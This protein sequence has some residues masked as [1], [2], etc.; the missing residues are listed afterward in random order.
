[1]LL[2]SALF[3]FVTACSSDSDNNSPDGDTDIADGDSGDEEAAEQETGQE[4]T[5]PDASFIWEVRTRDGQP[6]TAD[7]PYKAEE[8]LHFRLPEQLPDTDARSLRFIGDTLYAGTATG[9]V[10]MGNGED[11]FSSVTLDG[12]EEPVIDIADDTLDDGSLVLARANAV[13]TL[14][15]AGT[16]T[17][18]AI[19]DNTVTAVAVLN[20]EIWVGTTTGLGPLSDTGE[21]QPLTLPGG[22]T[23]A[24]T[25]LAISDD[26]MYVATADHGL[27]FV[28]NGAPTAS[29]IEPEL[30]FRA[31]D[32]C[33]DGKVLAGTDTNLVLLGN[34]QKERSIDPGPGS[35]PTDKITSVACGSEWWVIGHQTGGSAILPDLSHVDHYVSRRWVMNNTINAVAVDAQGSRWFATPEG[36][37]RIAL[38]DRTVYEKAMDFE[39]I[40]N[41]YFWRTDGFVASDVRVTDPWSFDDVNLYDK[42]NDGLWTQMMIGGWT[43]AAEVTGEQQY[44]EKARKAVKNM[45]MEIDLPCISFAAE[46]K[47]CGFI[48]RSFVR[49]DEGEVFTEK[50]SQSNWHLVNYEGHDYYWKDDTSSDEYAGHFF[51]YP[52]YYDICA[53]DDEK[54]VLSEKIDLVAQ[55]LIDNDYTLPDLDGERTTHGHWNPETISICINEEDE[56]DFGYCLSTAEDTDP[57]EEACYGGGWLNSMEIMGTMLSAYH[58]T[59]KQKFY[60]AYRTLVDEYKYNIVAIF[61]ENVFT[62]TRRYIQNHSDHELAILAYHTLIRYEPD[63]AQREVYMQSLVD[64]LVTEKK[65]RQPL[66]NAFEAGLA[67]RDYEQADAV[68]TI[69][70]YPRDL[71]EWYIDHSHRLDYVKDPAD[72]RHGDQ[73]LTAVPP[74]DEIRSM[75]WNGNPY[76]VTSGGDGRSVNGPMA[77]LL[78]Y[79]SMRYY[80]LLDAPPAN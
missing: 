8:S 70:E 71:R 49:D 78:A 6:A 40:L 12:V 34:M 67:G 63:D 28:Q 24:V 18:Y 73:Q 48:T 11:V 22:A 54:A 52:L 75:W 25:D 32:V 76:V 68:R 42:D 59:G 37:S 58:M 19:A 10:K 1:M 53:T 61:T 79:W 9:L 77:Y 4:D 7:E 51:G 72:D 14:S 36:I 13:V 17:A 43:F 33:P 41:D 35:L 38:V 47:K 16:A 44:C 26:I 29:I 23:W 74:Y 65:E 69:R 20:D 2:I 64:F 39:K 27:V 80:G 15:D 57:C 30:S 55:Y 62:A 60:D 56:V 5:Y 66:W 45:L 46:G 3:L 21:Y 31:L 50:A